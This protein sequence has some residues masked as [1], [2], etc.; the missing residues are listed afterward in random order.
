VR[1]RE[2]LLNA[3]FVRK[4]AQSDSSRAGPMNKR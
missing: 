1:T 2:Y 3:D 4:L